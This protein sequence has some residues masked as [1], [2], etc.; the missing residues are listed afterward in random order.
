MTITTDS[1]KRVG[2]PQVK[3]GGGNSPANSRIKTA[4]ESAA[5]KNDSSGSLPGPQNQQAK[6]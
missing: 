5:K 1:K 4:F 2:I 6:I 3:P